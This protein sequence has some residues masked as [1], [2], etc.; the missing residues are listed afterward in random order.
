MK[1]AKETATAAAVI[2]SAFAAI[3]VALYI[4]ISFFNECRAV[5]HSFLYCLARN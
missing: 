3:G 1:R 5:G 4:E 2:L